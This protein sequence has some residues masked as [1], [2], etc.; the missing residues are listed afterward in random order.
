MAEFDTV[1]R[2]A[3]VGTA[4]D[5]FST[6]IG[7]TGGVITVL[8]RGLGPARRD[9]DAAG[10]LVLPGGIDT[11]CHIDQPMR[12]GVAL[13]DDFLSGTV[14]AAHGGTTTIVPFAAQIHGQGVRTAVDDYHRRAADKPVIDY[15]FHLIVSD[16]TENVLR[17][18]LPSLIGEGYTS[19]KIYMTYEMLKLND[20]QVISVL[21][22]ARREGAM[23]MVHAENSDCITWLTEQLEAAG[24][25]APY[26]HA[27]SRP[28]AVEREGT[29]RAITMA[30]IVD[31]PILLVHISGAEAVEQIRWAQARGIR[32]YAETCPQYLV[33]TADDMREPGFESAKLVCSPPPRD[34]ASQEALWNG[35]TSGVFHTFSSDH[36]PFRFDGPSGKKRHGENAPFTKIPNGVP[37]IETRLPILF[38]EG[39][40]KG[41]IDL[42]TF[43]ALTA[44]NPAKMYGLYPRKGTIAVGSDA[45]VVI[46]D[47]DRDVTITN[48]M[49]HHNCDYTPYEGMRVRG[50]PAVVMSRGEIVVDEGKLLAEPGQGQFLRCARPALARRGVR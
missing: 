25:I 6:D 48:D 23:V 15:A 29:H 38:S 13:A 2:N 7:I 30:E 18:E 16:P 19:F 24:Q 3:V 9:V 43:V 50:W 27:V 41:R 35:M 11:H 34:A 33:L 10:R 20:R 40:N 5:V 47:R 32:I 37:G 21:A 39:V 1:I 26:Y 22:V 12:T 4:A 49:L 42:G 46:W 45:D 14:S 36:S 31:V 28:L 17:E 8:G 44:T